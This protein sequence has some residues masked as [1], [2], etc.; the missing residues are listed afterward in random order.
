MQR[1]FLLSREESRRREMNTQWGMFLQINNGNN[2][3]E[4][5]R[6]RLKH[7]LNMPWWQ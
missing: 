6:E 5:E 7:V 3:R 1:I 4:R 2:L